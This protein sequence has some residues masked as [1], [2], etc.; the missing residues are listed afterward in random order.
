MH[1]LKA[2]RRPPT[3]PDPPVPAAG[4]PAG[5]RTAGAKEPLPAL[6]SRLAA[7]RH[8]VLSRRLLR[9]QGLTDDVIDGALRRTLLTRLHRGVYRYGPIETPRTLLLAAVDACGREAVVNHFSAGRDWGLPTDVTPPPVHVIVP[10]SGRRHAGICVHRIRLPAAERTE[11]DGLP[12]TTP[13]RTIYDMAAALR[14]SDVERL[15]AVAE[16]LKLTRAST[17]RA[18]IERHPFGRGVLVLRE[19][20]GAD[21][22]ALTR[23]G[24]ED[25][26][27]ARVR[28]AELPEPR[29]N[30]WVGGHRV[31]AVWDRQRVIIEIDGRQHNSWS[32]RRRDRRRDWELHDAGYRVE[33]VHWDE[34][35]NRSHELV[36]RIDRLLRAGS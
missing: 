9:E 20:L 12:I 10:G 19:T 36:V 25:V 32:A 18:L 5:A 8:G 2:T 30:V 11:K 17:I 1:G 22:R 7:P 4:T 24:V 16:D 3:R 29:T 14:P 26:F 31:D 15:I 23:S 6:L 28:D 34:I 21:T 33:R 35:V 13:A 27:L